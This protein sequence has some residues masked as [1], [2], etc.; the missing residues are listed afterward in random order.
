MPKT[1]PDTQ[2]VKKSDSREF[3]EEKMQMNALLKRLSGYLIVYRIHLISTWHSF[4]IDFIGAMY[5][6]WIE[7]YCN[8]FNGSSINE[9]LHCFPLYAI[10]N[11]NVPL[12]KC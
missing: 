5:F 6:H 10:T 2:E 12:E 9:Y 1:V 11:T 3:S 4:Y 7:R 8:K